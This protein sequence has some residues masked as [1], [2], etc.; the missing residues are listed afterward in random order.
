M[1]EMPNKENPRTWL[2]FYENN[3]PRYLASSGLFMNGESFKHLITESNIH[4]SILN[5][6]DADD[7]IRYNPELECDLASFPDIGIQPQT[8]TKDNVAK[9]TRTRSKIRP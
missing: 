8:K 2:Q 4:Y 9:N 5:L 3:K 6:P 7:I 1:P